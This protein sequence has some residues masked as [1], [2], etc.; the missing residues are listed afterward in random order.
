MFKFLLLSVV[1]VL[2]CQSQ[3]QEVDERFI[4]LVHEHERD[5]L[6]RAVERCPGTIITTRHL[7]TT[8]AC[9][10]PSNS[11]LDIAVDIWIVF[12]GGGGFSK[13]L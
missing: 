7:L 10:I 11:S 5:N 13:F 8:A 12:P 2:F 9:A 1:L 4:V 6:G 3:A